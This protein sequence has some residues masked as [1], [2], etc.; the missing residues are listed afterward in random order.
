MP[1]DHTD[2]SDPAGY[3]ERPL[4]RAQEKLDHAVLL[5]ADAETTLAN[6]GV[7]ARERTS[8][9]TAQMDVFE[10]QSWIRTQLRRAEMRSAAADPPAPQHAAPAPIPGA[11]R[12]PVGPA[13]PAPLAVHLLFGPTKS[14]DLENEFGHIV[15]MRL[16]DV[17]GARVEAFAPRQT[18][19]QGVVM[20]G[21]FVD[22]HAYPWR[23][24]L[25]CQQVVE[26]DDASF[27]VLGVT[28]ICGDDQRRHDALLSR[29]VSP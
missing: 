21:R 20:T 7:P 28:E 12:A 10:L 29:P 25:D 1:D 19:T 24:T 5:L 27:V 22:L 13:P 4:R 8:I 26:Q 9:S 16:K 6:A 18:M 17:Q 14:A 23:V 11:P 15:T 2:P 3:H